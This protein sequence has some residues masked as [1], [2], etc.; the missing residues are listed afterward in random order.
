MI[1]G[2]VCV[3]VSSMTGAGEPDLDPPFPVLESTFRQTGCATMQNTV[4]AAVFIAVSSHKLFYRRG[5]SRIALLWI[6]TTGY[7]AFT[8]RAAIRGWR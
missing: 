7:I 4:R 3:H 6:R 5:F 8:S 1:P 2:P